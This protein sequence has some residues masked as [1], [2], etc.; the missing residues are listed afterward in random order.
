MTAPEP[1]TGCWLWT[2]S[3][4]TGYGRI[5]YR[6]R[7][8]PAHRF[9]I[10]ALYG[11]DVLGKAETVDHACF[12]PSCVNPAH[13]RLMSLSENAARKKR[14]PRRP[15]PDTCKNGHPLTGENL[16]YE[17]RIRRPL[18]T[19]FIHTPVNVFDWLCVTCRLKR[20]RDYYRRRKES[21]AV[22]PRSA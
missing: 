20:Q 21:H 3:T 6:D 8:F 11:W 5:Q 14:R 1:N 17:K 16:R 7:A 4:H 12:E 18:K 2:G 9:V 15:P 10:G 13:L 22:A 19:G